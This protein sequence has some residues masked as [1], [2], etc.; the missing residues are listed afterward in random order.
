[1]RRDLRRAAVHVNQGAIVQI[2]WCAQ[3]PI[4]DLPFYRVHCQVTTHVWLNARYS[5]SFEPGYFE[6]SSWTEKVWAILLYILCLLLNISR[7]NTGLP[8]SEQAILYV[9]FANNNLTSSFTIEYW[10]FRL[11]NMFEIFY[12]ARCLLSMHLPF[13]ARSYGFQLMNKTV[14][15]RNLNIF[16]KLRGRKIKTKITGNRLVSTNHPQQNLHKKTTRSE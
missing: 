4:W 15:M 5:R 14:K 7:G 11:K 6:S 8:M 16:L 2:C 10:R 13:K 1:M 9:S 12:N 3:Q